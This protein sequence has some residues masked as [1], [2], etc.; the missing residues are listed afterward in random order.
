MK[1]RK[2]STEEVTIRD[3]ASHAGV[4][5]SSVSRVM[6]GHSD[7][8]PDM[9]DRVEKSILALGYE[10]DF[11]AQSLRS[12]KT[13]TIG[14]IIRDISNPFYALVARSCEQE[15]RR[16]GYSMILTNSD[17]S[18]ETEFKNFALLRRRRVD[19]V[20]A[21]LVAEDAPIVRKTINSL[22]A[23]V[24]LLDREMKGLNASA[25]LTDHYSGVLAATSHL[26]TNGHRDIAFISGSENVYTTRDR[27]R[28]FKKAFAEAGLPISE[29]WLAL[30]GFDADYAFSHTRNLMTHNPSPTALI[31]GGIASTSGA[32]RA[33]SDLE[34]PIGQKIAFIALDEWPLF[35]VFTPQIS[36]VRR[37]AKAIGTEAALLMFEMLRGIAPRESA[38]ET[39][40]TA[41]FSSQ[42]K[43][44][45]ARR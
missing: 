4:A 12:G 33:L 17:G 10:P 21:S 29:K 32:L 19:G 13:R 9:K 8:S 1:K 42:H 28:G 24:V 11:M 44:R 40:F 25:V 5:L 30:G 18:V 45:P 3:V 39:Q 26:I 27:L 38:I 35:D 36:S 41:R 14:F 43:L 7:V 2:S 20:I 23:P 6:S 15:L 16:N 34:I 37:D 22:K 31:T